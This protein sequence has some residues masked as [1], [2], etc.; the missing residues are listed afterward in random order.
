MYMLRLS[1]PKE[2]YLHVRCS[3]ILCS[4]ALLP[5]DNVEVQSSCQLGSDNIDQ[6]TGARIF[7]ICSL[8][9]RCGFNLTTITTLA[10]KKRPDSS[11][12]PLLSKV[13]RP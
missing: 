11:W 4:R 13:V 5:G 10:A 6:E 7:S 8:G 12:F 3:D 1:Q 2:E 9:G